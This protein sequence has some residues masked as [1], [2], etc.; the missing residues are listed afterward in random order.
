MHI[1]NYVRTKLSQKAKKKGGWSLTTV[2]SKN[3]GATETA[4]TKQEYKEKKGIAKKRWNLKIRHPND[5]RK[6]QKLPN[7]RRKPTDSPHV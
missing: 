3:K 4:K 7:N 6:Q 2:T 5:K 1:V